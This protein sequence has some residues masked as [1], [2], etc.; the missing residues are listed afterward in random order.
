MEK[1]HGW[2]CRE[3]GMRNL[4]ILNKYRLTGRNLPAYFGGHEGDETCG[5]FSVLSPIDKA[6]LKIIASSD[7]GWEH[8]SVSR[9]N[10]CPNWTEMAYVKELFFQSNETVMQLHVPASDHIN[11]HP[12]CLH[13]WR[14]TQQDIPRPPG[15]MVGGDP[16]EAEREMQSCDP[17]TGKKTGKKI[18]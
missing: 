2:H 1:T 4:Y 18:A 12:N 13:L 3:A 6:P 7:Y 17:K 10:R 8:V 15:W 11:D 5:A 9:S 14:P 16:K